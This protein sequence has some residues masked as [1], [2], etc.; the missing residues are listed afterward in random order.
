[1][2]I[3]KLLLPILLILLSLA[4]CGGGSGE[5]LESSDPTNAVTRCLGSTERSTEQGSNSRIINGELC[6]N[7]DSP[8]VEVLLVEDSGA[9]GLCSGTVIAANKVLTAAHCFLELDV[10]D[11]FIRT[12]A[13]IFVAES[14]V[15]HPQ[16]QITPSAIF[17]DVAVITTAQNLNLP[18][19]PLYVS[20]E[21]QPG[22]TIGITG[23]GIT[24]ND[25]VGE[26]NGGL[27]LVTSVSPNHIF[28]DKQGYLQLRVRLYTHKHR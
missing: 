9:G 6:T 14:T 23:F 19:V 4:S 27:M 24:E 21:I 5:G 20:Q 18:A 25:V 1:M 8:I 22:Q 16:A 28:A 2:K 7:G 10:A 3:I 17:N 15:V 26:L 13:G 11:T 12:Q